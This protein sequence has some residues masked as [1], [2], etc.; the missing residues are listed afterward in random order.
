MLKTLTDHDFRS[1][2]VGQ[3]ISN[4]GDQ[5]HLI[6]LPWLVLTITADPLQ[7]GL[8]MAVAGVPRAIVMLFGGALADR[9]SPRTI[10]L[11]SNLIRMVIAGGLAAVVASGQIQLWMPYAVAGVFGIVSGL[12]LPS[13][14]ATL[15]RLLEPQR[16][17]AGNSLMMMA[18]Q[19]AQFAGPA[20]AGSMIALLSHGANL[21]PAAMVGIGG[22]FAVDAVSFAVAAGT[23]LLVRPLPA[24]GS[25]SH[26]MRDIADGLGFVWHDRYIR[27]LVILLALANLL[28]TGPLFVGLPTLAATRF[29]DGA[30]AYGLL[31]SASGLGN[32]AGMALAGATRPSANVLSW[33]SVG[34]FPLMGVCYAGL[35]L[36]SSST[37]AAV[38]MLV[39]GLGNGF[40]AITVITLVQR[41][42]PSHLVGRTMAVLMLSMYGLG[43]ISQVVAGLVL[44]LSVSWLFI[45]SA[46]GLIL[47]ATIALLNRS[48]WQLAP[49]AERTAAPE[50]P[51]F[52]SAAAEPGPPG[53]PSR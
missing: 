44:H 47:P 10:M 48:L 22:A 27:I 21:G 2:C 38:L 24:F 35:G 19:A 42:A 17:A 33:L 1:L 23:L 3:A 14:E 52:A 50:E 43:P 9:M 41:I 13:S 51:T 30:A 40:L 26:P 29:S 36:V 25:R 34:V 20:L 28:L 37:V 49:I 18:A 4:I 7:L 15:P 8:V 39:A 31:L 45:G 6:A 5:F 32:I 11:W 16:L 46:I 53:V 12:F